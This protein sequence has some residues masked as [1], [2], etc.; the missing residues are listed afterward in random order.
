MIVNAPTA[1]NVDFT[2]TALSPNTTSMQ[3]SI[4]TSLEQF[5]RE[6]VNVGENI[7]EDSYRSAIQSTVDSETGEKVESFT[8]STPSGDISISSGQLGILGTVTFS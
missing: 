8:L 6:D 4:N 1:V 7:T 2:F 5:F 3:N